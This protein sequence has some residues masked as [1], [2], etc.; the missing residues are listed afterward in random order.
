MNLRKDHS[1]ESNLKPCK[2]TG[3]WDA[4]DLVPRDPG[5]KDVAP[6]VLLAKRGCPGLPKAG[7][8][9]DEPRTECFRCMGRGHVGFST[10]TRTDGAT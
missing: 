4:L 5:P 1:H 7:P 2:L 9:G 6:F 3:V 10:P 8:P